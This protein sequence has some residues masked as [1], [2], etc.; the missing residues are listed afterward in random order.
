M[1]YEEVIPEILG[2]LSSGTETFVFCE[3]ISSLA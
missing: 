1:F 2:I 3:K